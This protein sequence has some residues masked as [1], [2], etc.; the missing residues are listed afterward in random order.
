MTSRYSISIACAAFLITASVSLTGALAQPTDENGVA[1]L[2]ELRADI[3]NRVKTRPRIAPPPIGNPP[4][5]ISIAR[6]DWETVRR[7]EQETR[8]RDNQGT[9]S[10]DAAL[11]RTAEGLRRIS[12][13]RLPRIR[14]PELRRPSLPI[15]VPASP[16]IL[17]SVVV[18]GQADSY[19][20]RADVAS[21]VMLRVAGT[22]KKLILPS[23]ADAAER[24]RTLRQNRPRLPS[25]DAPYV[26]T[27]SSSSTDLSFS[28][29]GAGYVVSLI[30][31]DPA[32][33]SRCA[34][35]AFIASLSSSM[36]LLNEKP[37][38]AEEADDE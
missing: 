37:L 3:E 26:I 15:L 22:R 28:A 10:P 25:L 36:A 1:P 30:C 18:Y 6:I 7:F 24:L 33:D 20:A 23:R 9:Q 35:D 14:I 4:Q 12:P 32:T 8:Q 27:R 11:E 16:E 2:D 38:Q 17:A 21:G 5:R 29:F 13:D 31:D 19:S 34:E